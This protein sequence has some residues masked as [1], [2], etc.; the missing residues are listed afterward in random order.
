MSIKMVFAADLVP[1]VRNE[2]FFIS[3]D[4]EYLYGTEMLEYL[5]NTDFRCFNLEISLTDKKNTALYP[6]PHL[7]ARPETIHGIKKL[8]P[9]LLTIGNNHALDQGTEGL[10]NT[11]RVLEAEEIPFTGAGLNLEEAYKPYYTE[12]KGKRIGIFNCSEYEFAAA[13][14]DACGVNPYDPLI[15]FDL[16]RDMR[17]KCDAL[18][19][20]YHGGKE[21]YRYPS[22]MVQRMCRKFVD[23]GADLVICQHTHCVGCE[24]DYKGSK[25]V[26]GQGNFLFDGRDTA[27]KISGIF[28]EMTID[29]NGDKIFSYQPYCKNTERVKLADEERAAEIMSGFYSRS[30]E[31]LEPGFVEQNYKKLADEYYAQYIRKLV[32]GRFIN[33]VINKLTFGWYYRHYYDKVHA[34]AALN[35]ISPENHSELFKQGLR[36]R[37][38]EIS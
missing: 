18:V 35:V 15:S 30:K 21:N 23:Y 4:A 16:V 5:G 38:E 33:K 3:G 25:I 2:A 34:L 14:E 19:V 9:S 22:P 17:D 7:M 32:G 27:E 37:A 31:I 6:G 36:N 28:V 8:N 13:T 26:Y 24:E 10:L 29:D 1:S 11:M 20:L 12:I